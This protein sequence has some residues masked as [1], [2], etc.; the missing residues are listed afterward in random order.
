MVPAFVTV[1]VR[2]YKV[3]GREIYVGSRL[4]VVS[5]LG[6][7]CY[8]EVPHLCRSRM[9]LVMRLGSRTFR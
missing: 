8:D 5:S 7:S 2:H 4:P 9:C 6:T 3:L 1:D